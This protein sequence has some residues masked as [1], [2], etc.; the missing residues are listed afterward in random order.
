MRRIAQILAM[1]LIMC[2]ILWTQEKIK[3]A[4]HLSEKVGGSTDLIIPLELAK[5]LEILTLKIQLLQ[6]QY[7]AMTEQF[8]LIPQVKEVLSKMDDLN[9]QI[10]DLQKSIYGSRNAE[11]WDIDFQ[12]D[13]DGKIT[14]ARFVKHEVRE[15]KFPPPRAPTG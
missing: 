2:P 5:D 1:T 7:A 12:R 6:S 10:A 15:A 9:K 4:S 11:D 8:K 3:E 14:S 13:K